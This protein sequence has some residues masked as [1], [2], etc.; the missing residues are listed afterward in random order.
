MNL[1]MFCYNFL[2]TKNIVGSHKMLQHIQNWQPNY[3]RIVCAF[4]HSIAKLILRQNEL[5]HFLALKYFYFFR[6]SVM[7]R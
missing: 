1:I 2:R 4:K 5:P 3:D 6:R 7:S